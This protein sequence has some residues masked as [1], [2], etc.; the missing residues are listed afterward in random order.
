MTMVGDGCTTVWI[1]STEP[2]IPKMAKMLKSMPRVMFYCREMGAAK[3]KCM[4]GNLCDII[5]KV[6]QGAVR[7]KW[8]NI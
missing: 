7:I 4:C 2:H 8:V 1:D 5:M 6:S 3:H